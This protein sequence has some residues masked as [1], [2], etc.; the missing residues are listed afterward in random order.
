MT[1]GRPPSAPA[2][3]PAR[4]V[5]EV[6]LRAFDLSEHAVGLAMD[7]QH[8]RVERWRSR[9]FM[10]LQISVAA[11]TAWFLGQHLLGHSMPFFASVAA[12]ICLGFS[13][14]QRVS[15]VVEVACGVFIGV[16]TG[17]LFVMLFGTGPW[18]IMLVCF[19]AMSVATW[20]NAKPLMIN[21]A[22]IQAATVMTLMPAPGEGFSRWADAL[23]GCCLALAFALV[24][25]TSPVQKPRR[26]AAAVL[27]Q[28]S[29]TV[30]EARQALASGDAEAAAVTLGH[31]RDTEREL[32]QLVE[33]AN[34]GVAV[35]RYS[36]F[37]RSERDHVQAIAEIVAPL[38]RLL[39]NLRVLS[40]RATIAT[41]RDEQVPEPYLRVLDELADVTDFCAEELAARRLPSRARSRIE[42]VARATAQ[43]GLQGSMSGIV[44][45]AQARSMLVDLL[46][47]TG[48]DYAEARSLVPEMD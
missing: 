42:L 47:L 44:V 19:V 23:L 37:L 25:P 17:D 8:R 40:R 4:V 18:Q 3:R 12:I 27:R 29:R 35:A 41:W 21:Q 38:D 33:A 20:F 48:M 22:G 5:G 11:G 32:A 26:K 14:G 43:M 10:I 6:A 31:A 30:R 1:E 7:E 24:A 16:M 15:R 45:L 28:V 39:R 36:P 9:L 2:P 34:E 46:E 13:F